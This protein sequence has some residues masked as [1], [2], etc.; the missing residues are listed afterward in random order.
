MV[1]RRSAFAPAEEKTAELPHRSA[2]VTLLSL[3]SAEVNRLCHEFSR[4]G[5]GLRLP[6]LAGK[7]PETVTSASALR[8]L[9]R[10]EGHLIGVQSAVTGEQ[11]A[12]ATEDGVL[13]TGRQG[14]WL[15]GIAGTLSC[16]HDFRP[17]G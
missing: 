12:F 11:A 6:V 4:D 16:F 14:Q 2:K 17:N 5:K 7:E 9:V 1:C 8:A 13:R 15:R 3:L 10:G